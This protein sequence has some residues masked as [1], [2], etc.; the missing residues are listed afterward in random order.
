MK[1]DESHKNYLLPLYSL[2]VIKRNIIFMGKDLL[3]SGM[4]NNDLIVI[5]GPQAIPVGVC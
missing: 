2:S 3:P 1:P 4:I 5:S